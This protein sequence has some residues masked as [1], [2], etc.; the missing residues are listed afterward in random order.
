MR[1]N[2]SCAARSY[3]ERGGTADGSARM[4]FFIQSPIH[5][6]WPRQIILLL[7]GAIRA[8]G[9][10]LCHTHPTAA[11]HIALA[12]SRAGAVVLHVCAPQPIS[13]A[14][15]RGALGWALLMGW[16]RCFLRA[17]RTHPYG[18]HTQAVG[19]GAD[20][21]ARGVVLACA[22]HPSYVGW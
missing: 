22:P 14:P 7:G 13:V 4:A 12:I 17:R 15:S 10:Y 18:R 19:W 9:Y 5:P 8:L 2:A 20:G 11:S 1:C 6:T 16:G 3:V 21:F